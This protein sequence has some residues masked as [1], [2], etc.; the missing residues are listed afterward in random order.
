M[1]GEHII[2][3]DGYIY[4][5]SGYFK[6]IEME[7]VGGVEWI[8]SSIYQL[9]INDIGVAHGIFVKIKHSAPRRGAIIRVGRR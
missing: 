8:K 4:E 6:R 9:T 7:I 2:I 5:I 3:V 1:I